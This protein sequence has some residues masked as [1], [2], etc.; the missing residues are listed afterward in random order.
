MVFALGDILVLSVSVLIIFIFRYLDRGNRSLEKAKQFIIRAQENLTNIVEEKAQQLKDLAINIEIYQQSARQAIEQLEASAEDLHQR[1]SHVDDIQNRIDQYDLAL[2]QL[3]DMTNQ[4]EQNI[5]GIEQES[6]YID[7]VGRRIKEARKHIDGLEKSIPDLVGK[8]SVENKKHL[9]AINESLFK[10][11]KKTTSILKEQVETA[12]NQAQTILA[13]F[14]TNVKQAEQRIEEQIGSAETRV[15]ESIEVMQADASNFQTSVQELAEGALQTVE[16][17][18][19]TYQKDFEDVETV[20]RERLNQTA[21]KTRKFELESFVVLQEELEGKRA[22][23]A[24][25]F[26]QALA[27]EKANLQERLLQHQNGSQETYEQLSMNLEERAE[28][29]RQKLAKIDVDLQGSIQSLDDL[30]HGKHE[31]FQVTITQTSAELEKKILGKL[32]Q[33]LVD[34]EESITYRLSRLDEVSSELDGLDQTLKANMEQ[35]GGKLTSDMQEL[36]DHIHARHSED[37]EQLRKEME[38]LGLSIAD[39]RNE[40]DILKEEGRQSVVG[41]FAEFE[42]EFLTDLQG[43]R[44]NLTNRLEKWMEDFDNALDQFKEEAGEERNLLERKYLDDF[45]SRIDVLRNGL[46]TRTDELKSE[47]EERESLIRESINALEDRLLNGQTAADERLTMIQD[48][49]V[50]L[51]DNRCQE[52]QGKIASKMEDVEQNVDENLKNM[53]SLI[54]RHGGKIKELKETIISDI[55]LWQNQIQQQLKTEEEDVEG[56]MSTFRVR[57]NEELLVLK[58]DYNDEKAEILAEDTK[59]KE[60]LL[61]QLNGTKHDMAEKITDF[62]NGFTETLTTLQEEYSNEKEGIIAEGNRV[63]DKLQEN[64]QNASTQVDSLASDMERQKE[65][66]LKKFQETILFDI[67]QRQ[68]QVLQQVKTEEGN[69]RGEIA[70]FQA[71]INETLAGLQEEYSNEK[72]GIISEGEKARHQLQESIGDIATQ[73]NVLTTELEGKKS[74]AMGRFNLDYQA[75]MQAFMQ[76]KNSA[77]NEINTSVHDFREFVSVTR[78]DFETM[79]KRLISNLAGELKNL[80]LNIK[81]IEKKQKSFLQQTKL[82]ERA[83]NLKQGLVADIGT[84]KTEVARFQ[85]ERKQIGEY[86]KEFLRIQKLG[87]DA[88][89][90]ML[91]FSMEQ[92]KL[93]NIEESYKRLMSLSSKLDGRLDNINAKHDSIQQIQLAI[94]NLDELQKGLNQRY[95]RLLNRKDVIDATLEGVDKNFN[96]LTELDNRIGDASK[97][98]ST[99]YGDIT[100]L[101]GQL[102]SLAA[103]KKVSDSALHNLQN[104]NQIVADIETRITDMQKAREWL[105]RMETRMEEVSS[106]ADQQVEMLGALAKQSRSGDH[107]DRSAPTGSERDMVVKLKHQGWNVEDIAKTCKIS[108]G[109]VE[110]IL[111]MA[112]S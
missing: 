63:R 89:E 14:Q 111:E 45:T 10:A 34:Y 57:M 31:E 28:E 44:H 19:A 86:E 4:A 97:S 76:Q 50:L 62:R 8:F 5:K 60:G 68:N 27:Q 103:D 7:T 55:T 37:I 56:E 73:V 23:M 49:S 30:L 75:F 78:G 72:A 13:D 110:L 69:V 95:D 35:L 84:L 71:R 106:Q 64:I 99:V 9:E 3:V 98:I 42:K 90:K 81:E 77:S 94:R 92:R 104:L 38:D 47:F 15:H 61:Q 21:E 96:Q 82:F 39:Y 67:N 18:V 65:E 88:N 6:A 17:S 11:S 80:E 2:K 48:Q 58:T 85:N 26:E 83:D 93:E 16:N 24:E 51:L 79:Q 100:V 74:E 53:D 70:A 54:L 1:T 29:H 43:R 101:K 105:A 41:Q 22:A 36:S 59:F 109:E 91:R 66:T 25:A 12:Q 40:L 46:S 52:I 102:E 112:H 20:F 107:P 32:E 33:R 87:K 108:R